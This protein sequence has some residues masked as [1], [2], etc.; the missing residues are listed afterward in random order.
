MMIY[1][2]VSYLFLGLELLCKDYLL[3]IRLLREVPLV[4][5][6]NKTIKHNTSLMKLIG[7]YSGNVYC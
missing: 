5:L 1:F 7:I 2:F 6:S 4:H 3:E